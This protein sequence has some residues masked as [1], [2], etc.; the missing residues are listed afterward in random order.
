MKGLV[1]I[2]AAC[3]AISASRAQAADQPYLSRDRAPYTL[4]S[5]N[6][7]T[8]N[9]LQSLI[10]R[11]TG[12]LFFAHDFSPDDRG[13]GQTQFVDDTGRAVWAF[14]EEERYTP[15]V[16]LEAI[17][18]LSEGLMRARIPGTRDRHFFTREGRQGLNVHLGGTSG[19]VFRWLQDEQ[20]PYAELRFRGRSTEGHW[21]TDEECS[22]HDEILVESREE[23]RVRRTYRHAG[24]DLF[25]IEGRCGSSV[26]DRAPVVAIESRRLT[27]LIVGV[28]LP[29]DDPTHW[30]GT[31]RSWILDRDGRAISARPGQRLAWQRPGFSDAIFLA[32]TLGEDDGN[33][34]SR[35]YWDTHAVARLLVWKRTPEE[36]AWIADEKSPRF[37]RVE[38]TFKARD[39]RLDADLGITAFLGVDPGDVGYLR[40]MGEHVALDGCYGVNGYFPSRTAS[41]YG[42]VM[43][44][45]AAG[46]Y[47]LQK[48]G[49][50]LAPKVLAAAKAAFE[51]FVEADE[52]GVQAEYLNNLV[53]AALYLKRAGV[54]GPDYSR[55]ARTWARRE[56]KRRP[57]GGAVIP[58]PDTTIRMMLAAEAAH[59]LTGDREFADAWKAARGAFGLGREPAT[60]R[61]GAQP[62]SYSQTS[63]AAFVFAILGH[64]DAGAADAFIRHGPDYFCDL[65]W[66]VDRAWACDDVAAWYVGYSARGLHIGGRPDD[67]KRVLGLGDFPD[68]DER[69]RVLVSHELSVPNPYYPLR[70]EARPGAR[71]RASR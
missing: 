65:G 28:D 59:E 33:W 15:I 19:I 47:V 70:L 51:S 40:A 3:L 14:A 29:S 35:R 24:R 58:W 13:V 45:L 32:Q 8:G 7:L 12:L 55:W 31:T 2:F 53:N 57:A 10:D 23:T 25:A 49:D 67:R 22:R 68:Y 69:G 5:M 61:F 46:G 37:R 62:L 42:G 64:E 16:R 44:G 39:G 50:P 56:M 43:V 54:S 21:V 63:P 1:W 20:L 48:Y 11:R 41:E 30:K 4:A 9:Y 66:A 60:F 17:R 71:A 38:F 18:I 6:S 26:L 52:R 34:Q 36:V 27:D